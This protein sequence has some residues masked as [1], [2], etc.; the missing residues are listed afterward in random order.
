MQNPPMENT[1]TP[2]PGIAEADW[3]RAHPLSPI[4]RV[5]LVLAVMIWTMGNDLSD[6]LRNNDGNWLAALREF[7]FFGWQL[8]LWTLPLSVAAG[9]SIFLAYCYWGWF[10]TRF[11]VT[12]TAVHLKI[13]GLFKKHRVADL[14]KIQS[15]DINRPL[16]ARLLGLSEVQVDVADGTEAALKIQFLKKDAA[17]EFRSAVL[18]RVREERGGPAS[19]HSPQPQ[20]TPQRQTEVQPHTAPQAQTEIP[21]Q[22]EPQPA[23]DD[24][25]L[26]Q[27]YL[28][29][30]DKQ[31]ARDAEPVEL[32]RLSTGRLIGSIV[33]NPKLWLYFAPLLLILIGSIMTAADLGSILLT[34]LAI[35]FAVVTT[36]WAQFNGSY[37][38]RLLHDREGLKIRRGMTNTLTQ[39]VPTGRVQAIQ[40]TQPFTWRFFGWYTVTMNVAGYGMALSENEQT[41]STLIVAA[42]ADEL[43]AVLPYIITER[44]GTLADCQRLTH[45]L[46]HRDPQ[47]DFEPAPRASRIFDPLSFRRNGVEVGENFLLIRRGAIIHKLTVL[48][49]GCVQST[50]VRSGPWQ[51]RRHLAN[52]TLHS[53]AGPV[54]P[55]A[56]NID[57]HRAHGLAA[58]Y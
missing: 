4:T 33:L 54:T 20:A 8:G 42:T 11:T 30:E 32:Y 23:P 25:Q 24:A 35:I 18:A 53:V 16:L 36:V 52:L 51:R 55:I 10:F 13:G 45:V 41:R 56:K 57:V 47:G 14:R 29:A 19:A 38:M 48:P 1:E 34:N 3:R 58:R 43:A 7:T 12:S 46:A 21:A 50:L 9:L 40:I 22:N 5:W 37:N 44:G 39:A 49:H 6:I 31:V 17:H 27:S 2:A 15:V 28:E 26:V